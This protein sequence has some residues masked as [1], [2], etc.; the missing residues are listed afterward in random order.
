MTFQANLL[1]VPLFG[2]V[3]TGSLISSSELQ[4]WIRTLAASQT[5]ASGHAAHGGLTM[6]A[7]VVHE[8]WPEDAKMVATSL[9][10]LA[11]LYSR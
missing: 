8:V 9:L 4:S 1:R 6:V 11:R 2:R 5:S 7:A 10:A 3:S